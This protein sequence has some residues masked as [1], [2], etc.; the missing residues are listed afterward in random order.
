VALKRW[1]WLWGPALAA[2]GLAVLLLPPSLPSQEGLL[3]AFGL[4][5]PEWYGEPGRQFEYDVRAAIRRQKDLVRSGRLADSVV[6]AAR[7]ARALRSANGMVTVVYEPPL[8][9][10]S[11]RV[12][13]RA[14]VSE[15]SLYPATGGRGLSVIVALISNQ[16]RLHGSDDANR[17]YWSSE[18]LIDVAPSRGACVVTINL[19]DPRYSRA[20]EF[21]GH[22]ASGGPSGRFVDLCALF[23]RFGRPGP[24]GEWVRATMRRYWYAGN[25]LA[26]RLLE[27]RR[28]IPRQRIESGENE[29]RPLW[30]AGVSWLEI[31][32]NHGVPVLC[33]RVAGLAGPRQPRFYDYYAQP[34]L[35][36]HIV[37]YLL[38]SGS[39]EQFASFWRSNL[40]P[41]RSLEAAYGRPAGEIAR[42]AF[43]HWHADAPPG[44]PRAGARL[45]LAGLF[46]AGT[47]LALALVAGRR[48]KT[49]I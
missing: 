11:A 2:L 30:A 31:G 26:R 13:L 14:A 44:G 25:L 4:V 35:R 29:P 10:D 5:E 41:A 46:W 28:A 23:A 7:G 34:Y 32:C 20:A 24:A 19:L 42:S 1:R 15:L 12:W 47:A 33:A 36:T 17:W 37:A 8:T 43:S 38:A 21:M 18:E 49:E 3:A 6:A 40:P 39:P 9:A 48:W 16:V 45:L 22:D 27:A